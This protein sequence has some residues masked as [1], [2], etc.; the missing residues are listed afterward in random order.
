MPFAASVFAAHV[1]ER[2]LRRRAVEHVLPLRDAVRPPVARHAIPVAAGRVARPFVGRGRL[3]RV[4]V[5]P[6]PAAQV[7]GCRSRGGRAR[8]GAWRLRCG[9]RHDVG[10][11]RRQRHV[12]RRRGRRRGA[13][14]L[15]GGERQAPSVAT[16]DTAATRDENGMRK[17]GMRPSSDCC[18]GTRAA[19]RPCIGRDRGCR[20]GGL[21]K[22]DVPRTAG[23][24]QWRG[25][26]SV[27]QCFSA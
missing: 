17:Y 11:G 14:G 3:Q 12:A 15:R 8:R 7:R 1:G 18:D 2:V 13:G 26:R 23:R 25:R 16:A 20:A 10:A 21:S 9:R 4:R 24:V 5:D 19:A 22:R 6:V 27:S